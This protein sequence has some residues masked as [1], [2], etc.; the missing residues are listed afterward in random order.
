MIQARFRRWN[1]PVG[2]HT[3]PG[4]SDEITGTLQVLVAYHFTTVRRVCQGVSILHVSSAA[5]IARGITV[6]GR[7]LG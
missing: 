7:S 1:Q 4:T 2:T 3:D 5:G 6:A